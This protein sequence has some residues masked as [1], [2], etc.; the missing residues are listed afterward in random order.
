MSSLRSCGGRDDWLLDTPCSLPL[1]KT[2][3][4]SCIH[5]AWFLPSLCDISP[6][7]KDD[8]S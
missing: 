6:L 7:S 1:S 5:Q 4:M 8:Q 2:G 3:P